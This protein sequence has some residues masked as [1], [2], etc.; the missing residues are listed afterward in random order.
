MIALCKLLLEA[1]EHGHLD[2][3]TL[4]A[5]LSVGESIAHSSNAHALTE[6]YNAFHSMGG[7]G[8]RET[9][10]ACA[11]LW[12]ALRPPTPATADQ[13]EGLL[14]FETVVERFDKLCHRFEISLQSMVNL[15]E[16]F[17]RALDLAVRGD[18]DSSDLSRRLEDLMLESDVQ[19]DH[20][21]NLVSPHFCQS[22]KRLYEHFSV[23]RLGK[24]HTTTLDLTEL[25]ILALRRTKDGIPH[26][27]VS[28]DSLQNKFRFLGSSVASLLEKPTDVTSRAVSGSFVLQ[29]LTA[30]DQVSLSR[31][32]LLE[33]ETTSL[34]KIISSQAHLLEDSGISALDSCLENIV[35]EVL[36][37]LRNGT[38]DEELQK[39]ASTLVA[40]I[41]S[42]D[43]GVVSGKTI[44]SLE[45]SLS[46]ADFSPALKNLNS[47][48]TYLRT[49]HR[50][51]QDQLSQA[52]NAWARLSFAYL[53]LYVPRTAFDPALHAQFRRRVYCAHRGD[54]TSCLKALQ[55]FRNALT[56]ESD[57]LR[58][59]LLEKDIAA[60]G[61]G[62]PAVPIFR[63][64]VSQFSEL[65]L[66][67]DGLMRTLQPLWQNQGSGIHSLPL[68]SNQLSNTVGMRRR[69]SEQYRAYDDFT[70]P[71]VGF[72]D[73]LLIAQRLTSQVR[74]VA[75][76]ES[77]R[78]P[79]ANV[80]PFVRAN[81]KSWLFENYFVDAIGALQ[82]DSEVLCWLSAL[83]VRSAISP[84]AAWGRELGKA[85]KESFYQFYLRWRAELKDEQKSITEKSS[86]YKFRQNDTEQD[87]PT[88]EELEELFPTGGE[89][90]NIEPAG[91]PA[92][93]ARE[94]GHV[95]A[96][97]HSRIFR[98]QEINKDSIPDLLRQWMH[99]ASA[100]R[101]D[102]DTHAI[103]TIMQAIG[104][105]NSTIVADDKA[106]E[107]TNIYS[108][109]NITEAKKLLILVK[110]IVKRCRE[111]QHAWPEH[112]VPTE[113]LRWCE[114]LLEA[115][116]TTPLSRLLPRME[117]L[118][119]TLNEWQTIASREFSVSEQLDGITSLII[120]WR[121]L[122]LSTWAGLFDREWEQCQRDAA[123]WWYIAYEAI[124]AATVETYGTT[125]EL[126]QH[127][128][129]LLKTLGDF[130]ASSGLGE[131]AARLQMLRGFES[132]LTVAKDDAPGLDS[133]RQALANFNGLYAHFDKIVA[134]KLSQGR[135]ELEKEVKSAM[136]VASWKDRNIEVLRQSAQ[137]SHKK[138]LRIVRKFR[139]LLAQPV[140]LIIQGGVPREPS[141]DTPQP[142]INGVLENRR[143]SDIQA[144]LPALPVWHERPVRFRNITAT[145]DLITKK[146]RVVHSVF[147]AP[148]QLKSFVRGLEQ[149]IE[150]LQK[151]TPVELTEKNKALVSHLKTRKRRLLADVLKD[152]RH[153]GFQTAISEQ[154]LAQQTSTHTIFVRLPT[155]D[156]Q[157]EFPTV[158]SADYEFHRLLSIMPTVRE[159]ARKH[160]DDLT[161]AEVTRCVFLLESILQVNISHRRLL[162]NHVVLF[163]DLDKALH[164]LANFGL[165]EKPQVKNSNMQDRSIRL[166]AISYLQPMLDA[167]LELLR[168]Q[169]NL[170]KQDYSE[171]LQALESKQLEVRRLRLNAEALHL[172]PPNIQSS[173]DASSE[174]QWIS[175]T[176]E[177]RSNV[178]NALSAYPEVGPI[179]AHL[180]RWADIS[181]LQS[182]ETDVNNLFRP[183]SSDWVQSLFGTLDFVLASVQEA[184]RIAN[185]AK[186]A[187]STG[188]LLDQQRVLDESLKSLRMSAIAEQ[189]RGL[190]S[191]LQHIDSSQAPSLQMAA[192]ISRAISPIAEAYRRTLADLIT[193]FYTFHAQTSHTGY[194]LAESFIQ[195]ATRGFCSPSEK[196][197]NSAESGN[198]ESATGLGEGE[199]GEDIS[200]EVGE[201]EDLSEIA[202]EA[203]RENKEQDVEDEKDAVDMADEEMEGDLG[204]VPR[205]SDVDQGDGDDQTDETADIDEEAGDGGLGPTAVDEKMWDSGH[206][207]ASQE[208]QAETGTGEPSKDDHTAAAEQLANDEMDQDEGTADE[209]E[210][211]T[212]EADELKQN[213][214]H[215]DPHVDEGT[216]LNLPEDMEP[217]DVESID[218]LE[219]DMESLMDVQNNEEAEPG[220]H[221]DDERVEDDVND[222]EM[223]AEHELNEDQATQDVEDAQTWSNDDDDTSEMQLQR[224]QEHNLDEIV[225]GAVFGE[226]VTAPE[227]DDGAGEASR[228]QNQ[229]TQEA[230]DPTDHSAQEQSHGDGTGAEKGNNAPNEP[231]RANE[232]HSSMPLKQIG[233]I[234]EQW[235]NQHR[236]IEDARQPQEA[237]DSQKQDMDLARAQFEHLPNDDAE[238]DTQ[239]L[240]AASAEQSA[241]LDENNAIASNNE[242]RDVDMRDGDSVDQENQK[243]EENTYEDPMQLDLRDNL[244][245]APQPSS[246]VGEPRN[247]NADP[248]AEAMHS[249]EPERDEVE[250]VD[251][252]LTNTHISHEDVESEL[253]FDEARSL[254]I[255]HEESTRNL[256]LMLTEHLRL[257]LHP[258]QATKMRG[259]FRTG[260][261]L[262]IRRIIP[263]IASSYKRDKI[264]M[265]RSVPTKRSYQVMLAIDDSKSMTENHSSG[266]AYDTL[267]LVA[268]S[269]SMLE[270]GE[271]SVVGFGEDVKI[272]RD[273][274][275]SFTADE[276]AHIFQHFTFS[277]NKTNVQRLLAESNELF[278][279]ARLKATGSS[280]DLWQLQ[281][282]ISDGICEDHPSIRQ[283][284]RQAHEER[285]MIVFIVVDPA[286]PTTSS[287]GATQQSILDLQTAEFVT[288]AAGDMQLKMTKYLDSFPFR[289]YLIVRNVQELPGVLAGALRQWFAEVVETSG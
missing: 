231:S 28:R 2:A 185:D 110:K 21:G 123:S 99:I 230:Q 251:E 32:E 259:D 272:A 64:K 271:L 187:D 189:L 195:I 232:D 74:S 144:D 156:E 145:A 39:A 160:A 283:L 91:A 6:T 68:N 235:Y 44:T 171:L 224:Q 147:S 27:D 87:E 135:I 159:S 268:K 49:N 277:Q 215:V 203:R 92:Q 201:G 172:L 56:G 212:A 151:S 101:E 227:K 23:L 279:S 138:L 1:I 8:E 130:A 255:Q 108:D 214:D 249:P 24:W 174:A 125:H 168:S 210:S 289:Y 66:D 199:G 134:E 41:S 100:S 83:S 239:A 228:R 29:Q 162:S 107:R 175:L 53:E 90:A 218:G 15:R 254:W 7:Q 124:I 105:L 258:T 117:N 286:V 170:S 161:P 19:N 245:E 5:F 12:K 85:I 167:G 63:P 146:A 178:E 269:M 196:Q 20:P 216:N 176:N 213:A 142:L 181:S 97:L 246:F 223:N 75:R 154:I 30:T 220:S 179:L 35:S 180:L 273:F 34:G 36:H 126:V 182:Q 120:E 55:T 43:G 192:V 131:F 177:L 165:C 140:A 202:Q 127:A 115:P 58:A 193:L 265:R 3:A 118:Y 169:R 62:S 95:V 262:N 183:E 206:D 9:R 164:E 158:A 242:N 278:R 4:H 60:L 129:G 96:S 86:V 45:N 204:D 111:L 38:E 143:Y 133:V 33:T 148:Q 109:P 219:S 237:S 276:G 205:E 233:D 137:F 61:E 88:P 155:L 106:R 14:R 73:C 82:T 71:I 16:S 153:M 18:H 26:S 247:A 81:L 59:R 114:E 116:H 197:D 282:I 57:T 22:F 173:D 267:A 121:R 163:T 46:A 152:V 260:K 31:L 244:Q 194:T 266:L 50:N 84:P 122:E 190:M 209:P 103:V 257:I 119:A 42:N 54:L 150:E 93:S 128:E 48:I 102:D 217:K 67:L 248:G 191:G 149:S 78:S 51:E 243:T 141:T 76:Q 69:L 94:L 221:I 250:D 65:Q 288:D 287:T 284:V 261:R 132:H 240:G 47:V 211:V 166:A 200:K 52:A 253:S 207:G 11:A 89:T 104:H 188:W 77:R 234:L 275:T 25:E 157:K 37:T 225:D 136:Q 198:V 13:L 280:S 241:T 236:Q 112:A 252:R 226:G 80:L 256:A 113:A 264:W 72:I 40:R 10:Q 281:L 70:R 222:G 208:K 274:S 263:Y 139:A 98:P 285:I 79:L 184:E 186:T 238:A 17:S 270:V 229:L